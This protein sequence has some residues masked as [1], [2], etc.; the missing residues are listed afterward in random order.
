MKWEAHE[1]GIL[2]PQERLKALIN[3]SNAVEVDPN[4][5]P[6]RYNYCYFMLERLQC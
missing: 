6:T 4:I 1:I 5:R 3:L 2:E